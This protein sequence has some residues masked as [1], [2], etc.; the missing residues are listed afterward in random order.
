MISLR[1]HGGLAFAGMAAALTLFAPLAGARDE[2]V[3]STPHFTF[4]SDFNANLNDALIAAGAARRGATLAAIRE[5]S[6]STGTAD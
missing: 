3:A 2:P 4:Y 6:A 5:S 1:V